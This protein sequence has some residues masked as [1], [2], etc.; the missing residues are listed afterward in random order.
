M[1]EDRQR[2]AH[3]FQ[4]AAMVLDAKSQRLRAE[5]AA[6]EA[7][8][9]QLAALE[10]RPI[11]QEASWYATEASA[12]GYEQWATRRRAEINMKLAAQRARCL[13]AED[14]AKLAF[15]RKAILGKMSER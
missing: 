11:E 7:L 9:A 1:R 6:K 14:E 15:G 12:F 8:H 2:L 10:V 13:E 3:L 4:M 5:N